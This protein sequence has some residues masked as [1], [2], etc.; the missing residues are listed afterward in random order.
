MKSSHKVVD[1]TAH[2]PV[3]L[4]QQVADVCRDIIDSWSGVH[5]DEIEVRLNT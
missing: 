3:A 2:D 5:T 1:C 4:R